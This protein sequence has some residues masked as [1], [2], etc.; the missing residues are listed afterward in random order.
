MAEI[1]SNIEQLYYEQE[2]FGGAMTD[3]GLGINVKNQIDDVLLDCV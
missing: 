3:S 1:K 2:W